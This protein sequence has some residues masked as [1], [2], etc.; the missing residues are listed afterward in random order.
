MPKLVYCK[1]FEIETKA[2]TNYY[3]LNKP[4]SVFLFTFITSV[5][6]K[7]AKKKVVKYMLYGEMLF[8]VGCKISLFVVHGSMTF[9]GKKA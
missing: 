5:L 9:T 8:K 4:S 1:L 6:N 7:Y 3:N 2:I